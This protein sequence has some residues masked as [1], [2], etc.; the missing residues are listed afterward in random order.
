MS[1]SGPG[2]DGPDEQESLEELFGAVFGLAGQIASRISQDQVEARLRRTLRA[3]GRRQE[4]EP[5]RTAAS[6]FPSRSAVS[7]CVNMLAM[8]A[9][10]SRWAGGSDLSSSL[11][12]SRCSHTSRSGSRSCSGGTSPR[13]MSRSWIRFSPRSLSLIKLLMAARRA[14]ARGFPIE[15]HRWSTS[16]IAADTASSASSGFQPAKMTSRTRGR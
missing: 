1:A 16:I 13:W 9:S 11:T 7:C 10:T 4:E 2:Y 8:Q 14:Y 5:A 15:S 12:H 3:A 6:V